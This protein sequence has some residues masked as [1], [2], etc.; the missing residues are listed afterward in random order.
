MIQGFLGNIGRHEKHI[1][2]SIHMTGQIFDRFND[3][4]SQ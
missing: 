1:R 3:F 4:L 2:E